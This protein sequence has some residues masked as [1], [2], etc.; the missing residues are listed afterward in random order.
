[1]N[2]LVEGLERYISS[3]G[4]LPFLQS[5][6]VRGNS[7]LSFPHGQPIDLVKKWMEVQIKSLV[8]QNLGNSNALILQGL[9]GLHDYT[10]LNHLSQ[11]EL[12]LILTILAGHSHHEEKS[13]TE[14]MAK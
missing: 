12:H 11:E 9:F 10:Y 14:Q 13:Y 4:V 6:G 8:T 1:L 2:E 5:F 7:E 3:S